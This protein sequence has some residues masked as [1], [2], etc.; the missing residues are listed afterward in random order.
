MSNNSV[1]FHYIGRIRT[2]FKKISDVPTQPH[3][4]LGVPG[5]V[6]IEPEYREGLDGLDD[7]SYIVLLFHLHQSHEYHLK[8]IPHVGTFP[9]GVFATRSPKR[10]NPIGL[11]NVRLLSIE[12][13][14]VFV[15]NVDMLDET[16]ILD[17]KPYLPFYVKQELRKKIN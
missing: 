7:C 3:N 5:R 11:S 14:I 4:A 17:I 1:N 16:P 9:R 8:T 10:P 6:I 15:E 2:P 12:D 13:N